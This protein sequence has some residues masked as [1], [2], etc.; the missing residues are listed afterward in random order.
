[1]SA[2]IS[3]I[4]PNNLNS[5]KRQQYLKTNEGK[6]YLKNYVHKLT[7]LEREQYFKTNEGRQYLQKFICQPIIPAYLTKTYNNTMRT[8]TEK[9]NYKKYCNTIRDKRNQL[10][11]QTKSRSKFIN[12]AKARYA[13]G[14]MYS[15]KT[16]TNRNNAIKR[17]FNIINK[18]M[19]IRSLFT[20]IPA[21]RKRKLY[22]PNKKYRPIHFFQ[23]RKAT[24]SLKS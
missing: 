22:N 8:K 21:T 19:K 17:Y 7:Q 6:Q 11:E 18:R 24:V 9:N 2:T 14:K 16:T 3:N 15:S 5:F 20:K 10:E 1:M 4:T 12:T 23:K 13:I